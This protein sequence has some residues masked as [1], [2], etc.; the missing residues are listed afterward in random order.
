MVG[1]QDLTKGFHEVESGVSL[2][3]I[4]FDSNIFR[5]SIE[6]TVHRQSLREFVGESTEKPNLGNRC[7]VNKGETDSSALLVRSRTAQIRRTNIHRQI[8]SLAPTVLA[9]ENGY[10]ERLDDQTLGI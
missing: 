6:G 4:G 2:P 9:F 3:L 5:A 8:Q 7:D 1:V 10:Q